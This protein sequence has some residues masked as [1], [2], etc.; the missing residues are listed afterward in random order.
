MSK[1]K[2]A[3]FESDEA[4][5]AEKNQER[6][7][8]E[9]LY[10]ATFKNLEEGSVVEAAEALGINL[11]TAYSRLRRG[12]QSFEKALRAASARARVEL[13]DSPRGPEAVNPEAV[14]IT[15]ETNGE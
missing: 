4:V 8:L 15:T 13:A 1:A 10:D 12:R 11:N 14:N 7:E 6:M 5:S 2:R 9:A 3:T